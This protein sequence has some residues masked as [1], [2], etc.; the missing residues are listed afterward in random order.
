VRREAERA[1]EWLRAWPRALPLIA[2]FA[3]KAIL[4]LYVLHFH[5]AEFTSDAAVQPA[6]RRDV[7]AGP[8]VA[9]RLGDQ[10]R[11]THGSFCRV[12]RPSAHW[13]P[14]GF[15]VIRSRAFLRSP[16]SWPG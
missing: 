14:N 4:L 13:F 15:G 11:R 9:A 2:F 16:R 1:Q 10:Q 7:S 12:G 6:R 8:V 5:K 3:S